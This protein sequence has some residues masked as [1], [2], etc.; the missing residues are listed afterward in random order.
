MFRAFQCNGFATVIIGFIAFGV[1]HIK[2][3]KVHPW[4]WLVTINAILTFVTF[5]LYYLYFPDNPTTARF[6]T[7][8]EKV[9]AV[10]RVQD[11]RNGIETKRFKK[12]QFIEALSDPKTYLFAL[13]AGFT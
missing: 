9:R 5:V 6:L 10:K 4:K 1:A 7:A 11:N 2:N 8:E 12:A 3:S 13:A